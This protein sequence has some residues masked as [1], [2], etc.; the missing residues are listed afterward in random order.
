MSALL[1]PLLKSYKERVMKKTRFS[2]LCGFICVFTLLG[3]NDDN[4][5]KISQGNNAAAIDHAESL[6]KQSYAGLE[7]VFLDTKNIST[8]EDKVTLLI[9]GKNN[10]VYCDKIKDD[11]KANSEIKSLLQDHFIPYYV[12]VSY[13]KIHNLNFIDSKKELSSTALMESYVKSPMRPTPTL[14][15]LNPKGEVIFE[16]P[17]YMKPDSILKILQY[18]QS[19]QWQDKDQTQVASEINKIL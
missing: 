18:M 19:K 14:I 2:I 12:N 15:F 11:I 9:F 13:T 3:C 6:D 17:G 10:C 4:E 16:L 7:D 8:Q 5:V 1:T